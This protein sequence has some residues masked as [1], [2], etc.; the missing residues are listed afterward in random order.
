[1]G[2]NA[3]KVH[4]WTMELRFDVQ[5]DSQLV[6]K[7]VYNLHPTFAD[8]QVT[9]SEGPL[10]SLTRIGWG[11]FEV[12]VDVYLKD[13]QVFKFSHELCFGQ[14]ESFRTVVLPL[15]AATSAALADEVGEVEAVVRSTFLFTDGLANVGIT[16]ADVI[17]AAVEGRM[18]QLGNRRS[19]V[20]A[21][22]FGKD[23]SVEY[24]QS[25]ARAGQG[26]YYYVE[27][28]DQ[29]GAA[30]GEALGGLL[31]MSYQNVVL[32]LDLAFGVGFVRGYTS[33]A[34][35]RTAVGEDGASH[36]RIDIGDMFAEERRDVLVAL[37]LPAVNDDTVQTIGHVRAS[38]FSLRS[39]REEAASCVELKVH[40]QTD[41][42]VKLETNPQV[43]LHWNR[44]LTSTALRFARE[45]AVR[46]DLDGARKRLLEARD[47]V[48]DSVSNHQG[49]V[50]SLHFIT[51]IN[52]CLE[53]L[54]DR[55]TYE[56]ARCEKKMASYE[57]AHGKQRS[58]NIASTEVYANRRMMMTK[59]GFK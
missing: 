23:H 56:N 52:E 20:S 26:T 5:E 4:K 2:A 32:S 17:C 45:N 28:E 11:Y 12:G 24:L 29:I 44:H 30:F 6:D 25:I 15:Q 8:P 33:F 9:I 54:R 35:D 57:Q 41:T 34:I 3:E 42:L 38:G 19:F 1:M 47:T 37:S 21:F 10:F 18:A 53:D 16:K 46:G 50:R 55:R 59:K 49:D 43:Q 27:D 39:S 58:C 7:V 14:P 13:G 31:S 22:G 36:V 51:D 48:A 40:R